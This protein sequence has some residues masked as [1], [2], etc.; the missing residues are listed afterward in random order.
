MRFASRPDLS[1]KLDRAS[2]LALALA[3]LLTRGGERIGLL[4]NGAKPASGRIAVGRLA[5][6]LVE[7]LPQDAALPPPAAVGKNA[8][9]VWLSDFLSPLGD[10]ERAVRGLAGAGLTGH[11]VH[12]VDPVE[13]DFP[14]R[15]RTR[16]EW[17]APHRSEVFG[18]AERIREDYCRRFRAQSDAV[19]ALARGLGWSYLIHRTDRQ[20]VKA[21]VALYA[22]LAGLPL[23][24]AGA[25]SCSR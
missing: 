2:L 22:E 14:F 4:G 21:L 23:D 20:P 17:S 11:L 24:D 5:H 12:I 19:A 9:L 16:F 18:R 13:Q 1:T 6:E 15:G 10:I 8:Q 7:A 25:Q 3:S